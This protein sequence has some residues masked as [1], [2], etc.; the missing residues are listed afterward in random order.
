M[1]VE[2]MELDDEPIEFTPNL[3]IDVVSCPDCDKEFHPPMAKAHLTTHRVRH[4]SFQ[5][6]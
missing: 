2:E 1:T 4:H 3:S 5:V 6:E